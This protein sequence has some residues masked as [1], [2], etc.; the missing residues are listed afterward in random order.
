[1]LLG[2]FVAAAGVTLPGPAWAHFARHTPVESF[3]EATL[4]PYGRAEAVLA[5]MAVGLALGQQG[6]RKAAWGWLGFVVGTGLGL[7]GYPVLQ[8][9]YG[10][11]GPFLFLALA[12]GFLTTLGRPLPTA[13]PV[14]GCLAGGAIVGN[15]AWAVLFALGATRT[16]LAGASASMAVVLL[17]ASGIALGLPAAIRRPWI[18][19]GVRVAGSWVTAIAVLLLAL[20][21]R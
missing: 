19:I 17:A 13:L 20:G 18:R 14:A 8:I 21:A 15:A 16:A 4:F 5:M 1:M 12:A 2:G 11:T 6:P 7:L 9:F 3:W 10:P